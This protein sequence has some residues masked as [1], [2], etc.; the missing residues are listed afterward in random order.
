[1]AA[2][3][4]AFM[5]ENSWSGFLALMQILNLAGLPDADARRKDITTKTLANALIEI[6]KAKHPKSGSGFSHYIFTN[7]DDHN[8]SVLDHAESIAQL[9]FQVV[10]G[11]TITESFNPGSTTNEH[12]TMDIY[13]PLKSRYDT[14]AGIVDLLN[15][16]SEAYVIAAMKVSTAEKILSDPVV[17]PMTE[18]LQQDLATKQSAMAQAQVDIDN[19]CSQLKDFMAEHFAITC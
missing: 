13:L 11:A 15:R 2:G 7:R 3:L 1:M 16:C 4:A 9:W 5:C 19:A 17:A 14:F 6:A 8:V 10:A 18:I 12:I